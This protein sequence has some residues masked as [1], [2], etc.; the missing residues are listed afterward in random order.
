MDYLTVGRIV[1]TVGLKGEVKVYP[2]THFRGSRFKKSNHVF[3]F[4]N[5]EY[6]KL[7]IRSHRENGNLDIIAFE[8]LN[9]IDDVEVYVQKDL[10]VLKD[11]SFLANGQYFFVDLENCNVYDEENNYIG[12]VK[13]IEEYSSYST[14][15]ISRERN[16]DV[17]IPFVKTFIKSV[18]INEKKIIVKVI[19]GLL[20]RLPF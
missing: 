11:D 20:W 13:K 17:L 19:E 18:D 6:K 1:K 15:R 16:K 14:L 10:F 8:G 7:I 4:L 2:T 9:K 12:K 3:I 5:N